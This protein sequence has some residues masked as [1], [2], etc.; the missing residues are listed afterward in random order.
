MSKFFNL[1]PVV[2]FFVATPAMAQPYGYLSPAIETEESPIAP[3]AQIPQ[4]M[5]PETTTET[6]EAFVPE[7]LAGRVHRG[8]LPQ[9]FSR[10]YGQPN[11]ATSARPAGRVPG[12]Q[13]SQQR[14]SRRPPNTTGGSSSSTPGSASEVRAFV[15]NAFKFDTNGDRKLAA[16]ELS[17]LFLVLTSTLN[18]EGTT[19]SSTSPSRSP[20][21]ADEDLIRRQR[22]REAET[23]FLQM[24][25]SFDS[26][27]D[28]ALSSGEVSSLASCVQQNN[29]SLT[30]AAL[31]NEQ[32]RFLIPATQPPS[33]APA[34]TPRSQTPV[35]P[36]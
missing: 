4:A 1:I 28:G 30:D 6:L 19:S 25:L 31:Q 3:V 14:S 7:G 22:V 11:A 27:T 9:L 24:A 17:S 10:N 23:V 15:D 35:A 33:T 34:T 16:H 36:N 18:A 21:A 12:R 29:F 8:V 13:Q 26:N 32:Q 20:L 2:L 5:E